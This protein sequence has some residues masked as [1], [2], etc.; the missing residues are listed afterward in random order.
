MHPLCDDHFGFSNFNES[1]NNYNCRMSRSLY[2]I[3]H[4][5]GVALQPYYNTSRFLLQFHIRPSSYYYK[6]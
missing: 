5:T 2:N 6:V 1:P 3:I 4:R